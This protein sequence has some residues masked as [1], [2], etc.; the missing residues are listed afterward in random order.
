MCY[1]LEEY[2]RVGLEQTRRNTKRRSTE[3]TTEDS[4]SKFNRPNAVKP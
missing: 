2:D 4:E 1:L 3:E